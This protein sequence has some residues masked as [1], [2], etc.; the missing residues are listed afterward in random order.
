MA[1]KDYYNIL[2]VSRDASRADIKKAYKRLAKK[3]HP[4]LNKETGSE[5]KFKEI[6]QAA[7]VLGDDEK[8]KMYDMYGAE[9]LERGAGA[10]AGGFSGFDFSGF[11]FSDFG[12]GRFDFDD[13]FD[14]FFSGRSGF[15]RRSTRSRRA[16]S[17]RDL[18][19]EIIIRL[20]EAVNGVKKKIKVTKN[21]VC[22]ACNG[23]GGSG[24]EQCPECKGTGIYRETKRTPFGIFQ[25]N[26]TCR[27]CQGSG[28]VITDKCDVCGGSG[29]VRKTKTIEVDIPA[30]IME[31]AR[32]RVA[33]EGEAGYRGARPG[34]L[35]LVIHVEPHELFE[36]QGDD[37]VLEQ[38]I[39]FAQAVLG[40]KI[41]VPTIEGEANLKI[42]PGTTPGTVLKMRGAGVKHL[43][44]YGRGDQLIRINV[45]VPENLSKK[46][47]E[48]LKE[49][50]KTLE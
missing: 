47:K 35:Y 50:D 39:S 36:R 46:Q 38:D 26:T 40:D 22:E 1:E 44:S 42:P 48:L 12:F 16:G 4:D 7:S 23:K 5:E 8:R 19:H 30:G 17:G 9:G 37:L 33:Q 32:L 29:M 25:T 15:G 3:Y 43:N 41:K 34:D 28:E 11:D 18:A 14:T 20:E 13:I 31:G 24:V 27:R 45:K 6:N 21:D 49:F 10:G 2:G